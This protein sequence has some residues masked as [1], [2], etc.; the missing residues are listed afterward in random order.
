MRKL[1]VIV[2]MFMI[3]SLFALPADAMGGGMGSGMSGGMGGSGMMDNFGSGLLDWFQK[4]RNGSAYTNPPGQE[5]NQIQQQD[6]RHD[7]DSAYLNYQIRMKEKQLDALLASKDPDLGKVRVL[8]KDIRELRAEAEQ[9]QRNYELKAGK[10]NPGYGS[11]NS[12]GSSSY[13][14]AGRS[15]SA[16]MG[17]VGSMGSGGSMGGYGQG[18]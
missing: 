5:R 18:R 16:G 7:E 10:M 12:D 13:G 3:F 14:S 2:G 15:G 9:E 1:A 17:Y 4:W 6:Q 8:N 11:G